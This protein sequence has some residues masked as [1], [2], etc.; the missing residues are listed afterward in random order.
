LKR[1]Y[2]QGDVG[3]QKWRAAFDTLRAEI[4]PEFD[5]KAMAP[6]S[7]PATSPAGGGH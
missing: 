1:L 4:I 3:G 6:S 2:I 5:P 7:Q